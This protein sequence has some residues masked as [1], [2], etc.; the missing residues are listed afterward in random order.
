MKTVIIQYKIKP[1]QA[2]NVEI[3]IRKVF[4]EL[5]S[6]NPGGIAYSAQK[7]EDGQT[8]IH[9]YVA[10]ENVKNPV[11]GL[12]PFKEL[13]EFIR[14]HNTENPVSTELLDIDSY[15]SLD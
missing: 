11:I 6:T 9:R 10:G 12:Q 4:E 1:E 14:L 2:P 7:S 5:R 15:H 13:Q 8:F 3:L